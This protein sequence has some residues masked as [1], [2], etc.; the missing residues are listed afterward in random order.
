MNIKIVKMVYVCT[1]EGDVIIKNF[2]FISI[3]GNLSAIDLGGM[4]VFV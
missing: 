1:M 2:K 4:V 3:I